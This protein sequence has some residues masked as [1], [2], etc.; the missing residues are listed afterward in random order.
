MGRR[1][2]YHDSLQQSPRQLSLLPSG[3]R[4][5]TYHDSLQHTPGQLSLLPLISPLDLPRQPA[6]ITRPTQPPT[7]SGS[8][9]D[10]PRQPATIT[11]PTQPPTLS[12]SPLDLS[13]DNLQY[14]L[15]QLSL[16][17]STGREMSTGQGG[18]TLSLLISM[19]EKC[20]PVPTQS[21][22]NTGSTQPPTLNGMGNGQWRM[23]DSIFRV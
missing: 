6:T 14:T 9:L 5:S 7:L 19:D 23:Q 18:A 8:P 2:T 11:R 20:V 17:P 1:S 12:G 3:G 21:V 22:T 16:L 4:R 10:L 13:W 15:S